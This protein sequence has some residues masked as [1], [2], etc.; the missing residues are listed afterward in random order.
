M[1]SLIISTVF[2]IVTAPIVVVPSVMLGIYI[3]NKKH[4]TKKKP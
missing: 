3:Y 1:E 4:P 2:A